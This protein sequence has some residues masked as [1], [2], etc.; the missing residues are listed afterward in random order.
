MFTDSSSSVSPPLPVCIVLNSANPAQC[1]DPPPLLPCIKHIE[2]ENITCSSNSLRSLLST[3]LTLDN[4]VMCKLTEC[5]ILSCK[6]D[7]VRWEDTETFATLS[8]FKIACTLELPLMK[9]DSPGLWEALHGLDIKGL[10]LSVRYGGL[11]VKYADSMSQS[12]SSLTH[13]DTLSIEVNDDSPGLWEALHG[14]NIKSLSLGGVCGGFNVKYADSMSQSLLSLTYLDKLSIEVSD[15]S[16]CLWEALR[17]LDIKRLCLGGGLFNLNVNHADSMSQSLSSLSH[18]D[19]LSIKMDDDSPG[20]WEALLGLNIKSMSMSGLFYGLNVHY[21]DSMSQS[22]SSLTH[23][24]TLSIEVNDDSPGLW[25]ALHGLNIKSL[26]MSGQYYLGLNV[27]YAD[28]MSQSLS[29]LTHLDTLSIKVHYYSPGLWEALRGL[30]IKSLSLCGRYGDLD[31]NYADSMSQ[32]LSSLSHLNTLSIEVDDNSPGLW[33]ALRGLNIKSLSLSGRY[34]YLDVNYA[35][36]MSQSLSSLSHLNTLSIKVDND[37]PGLWEALRGLNIKS[38]SLSGRYGDL[39]VNYAD[40]MSQSRSSLSHLNTLSIEVDHYKRGLWGA[41]RGLNIKSLSLSGGYGGL[42]VNYADSMSQSLSSLTHLDTLSIKVNVCNPG[43]YEVLRALNNLYYCLSRDSDIDRDLYRGLDVHNAD[44]MSQSLSSL[45]HLDTLSIKVDDD[46][47]G[48]WEALRGLNIKSLSLSGRYRGLNVN[49]ADSMSQSL[50]SLTH[51]DS[52]SIKVDFDDPGLWQ[53]LRGLNIISLSLSGRY[54]GLSV[55]YAD[56]MSQSLSSLTHL[57]TLSIEVDDDS[58][59]L[60][61]ALHGLN[62]KSLIL[63]D[64]HGYLNIKHAETI[65]HSLS[66]LKQLEKLSIF[67]RTYIDIKLPQSLKY[68]NIYCV[69]LIPSELHELVAALSACTRTVESKLEFGCAFFNDGRVKSIPPEEYISIQLELGTLNHVAVKRFQILHLRRKTNICEYNAA[70]PWSVRAICGVQDD[71]TDDDNVNDVA[72]E[73]F[74]FA[75]DEISNGI[76]NRIAMRLLITPSS[77]S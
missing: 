52:L 5:Y 24:D 9:S 76:I 43:L 56:S 46:S 69:T 6:E 13:L 60:W 45:T 50:S 26:S 1:A 30:N 4:R 14:L 10:S 12:L 18:L 41:L 65:A 66:A 20:L 49:Y 7:A 8:L 38:L 34:G 59:G 35:D 55:N 51:L 17:G 28:S 54:G 73:S 67:L 36:S 53:A 27:N 62:I 25:E 74:V 31:V 75:I 33:E 22:L 39:D 37:S 29:S 61:K 71:N 64:R 15:D 2:L 23:L 58:P 16:P 44:S 3:L 21:A 77:N 40:S 68:L 19:T 70:S 47:P 42:N 72:Y 63:S 32:S 11:N 48:L 57:D